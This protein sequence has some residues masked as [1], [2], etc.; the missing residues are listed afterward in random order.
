LE[1]TTMNHFTPKLPNQPSQPTCRTEPG[2]PEW[3]RHLADLRRLEAQALKMGLSLLALELAL[4]I[5]AHKASGG[6][7][8]NF[9]DVCLQRSNA[10]TRLLA[11]CVA[12]CPAEILPLLDRLKVEALTDLEARRFLLAMQ[13]R[14]P[15]LQAADV[16][17]Q[18]SISVEVAKDS[19]LMVDYLR[20][21]T[22]VDDAWENATEAIKELQALAITLSTIG[23]LQEWIASCE[24]MSEFR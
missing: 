9:E 21:I 15:E 5:L 3:V 16:D 24:A 10:L 8:V 12:I 19:N 17:R 18:I 11:G 13:A 1:L 22:L 6:C 23:G 7:G 14:L 4:L 20:W 2:S